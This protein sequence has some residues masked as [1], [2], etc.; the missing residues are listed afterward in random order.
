M[1]SLFSGIGG[2]ELGAERA[3]IE[4]IIQCENNP[5]SIRI[6][7][8]HWPK[9]IR[10]TDIKNMN[11]FWLRAVFPARMPA[12]QTLK[13]PESMG[14][15]PGWVGMKC[16]ELY[17]SLNL[18]TYSLRTYQTSLIEDGGKSLGNW[19]RAGIVFGTGL[20]LLKT[21]DSLL[22]VDGFTPLLSRPVASDGKRYNTSMNA[23]KKR[24]KGSKHMITLPELLIGRFGVMHTPSFYEKIMG[25][26]PGHTEL[27][28]SVTP[29]SPFS[30]K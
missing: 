24:Y 10:Y 29:V 3:G 20:F 18:S 19:P 5:F 26:P 17:G 2:I 6:L 1:V 7:E 22:K 21:S 15:A 27:P 25:F 23:L 28:P 11:P 4:T 12:G 14:T 9:C 16:I 8:K 13:E 30:L